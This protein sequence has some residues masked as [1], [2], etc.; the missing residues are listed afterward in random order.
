VPRSSSSSTPA[1]WLASLEPF[2]VRLGLR[3]MAALLEE[4]GRPCHRVPAIIVA[5]SNGKGSTS[6]FAAAVLSAA[7][8]RTLLYTSPHVRSARERM[9][10]DGTDIPPRA[11]A[12]ALDEVRTAISRLRRKGALPQHPTYFEVLTAAALVHGRRRRVDALVLEVGLGGRFDAV[13]AVPAEVAVITNIAYEHT[14][15]LGKTLARIAWNKAGIIKGGEQ[16]LT[17]EANGEALQVIRN[18]ARRRGAR[19]VR[20]GRA[21]V[22]RRGGRWRFTR[23]ALKRAG[24]PPE[25]GRVLAL[26]L[27]GPHQG[28]NALLGAAAAA[29]LA[30]ARPEALAAP[31]AADIARGLAR[32]HLPGRF[33]RRAAP[34]GRTLILDGAHNPAA[35][36][37]LR[38]AVQAAFP[39]RTC[40]ILF[41]VLDDK[42]V[43]GIV[44][45]LLRHARMIVLTRPP[46]PRALDPARI[47]PHLPARLPARV[48]LPP[49]RALDAALAATP[50]GGLLIATGSFTLLGALAS[51]T[52]RLPLRRV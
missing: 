6:A 22:R 20:F 37:R 47:A 46:S 26:G 17:S 10:V 44:H 36:A 43:E 8:A 31:R 23:G 40:T 25:A 33:E 29:A 7:G 11:L 18:E 3:P 34:G 42:D 38:E 35:A 39:R 21:A 50:P 28:M 49:A 52:D 15:I 48:V 51:R 4:L 45:A 9:R 5:G 19:L 24:L 30:R 2:G 32:A 1:R 41:G 12:R 16:V 27:A 14:A 13:N